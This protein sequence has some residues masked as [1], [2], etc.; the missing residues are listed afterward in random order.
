MTLR[1]TQRHT[2][3]T[4]S[5][6]LDAPRSHVSN[7]T[8]AA[9]GRSLEN[10][11]RRAHLPPRPVG[12]NLSAKNSLRLKNPAPLC[13]RPFTP[14]FSMPFDSRA[15]PRVYTRFIVYIPPPLLS[16]TIGLHAP[17]SVPSLEPPV[18]SRCLTHGAARLRATHTRSR[19]ASPSPSPIPPTPTPRR[20]PIQLGTHSD[21]IGVVRGVDA[22]RLRP[23]SRPIPLRFE[24]ETISKTQTQQPQPQRLL[25]AGWP[26]SHRLPT[27]ISIS[28]RK[29]SSSPSSLPLHSV[30]CPTASAGFTMIVSNSTYPDAS[31]HLD[32][33]P[34]P[35]L[36]PS[37]SFVDGAPQRRVA[38]Y[39]HPRL[40]LRPSRL[41]AAGLGPSSSSHGR[42]SSNST[43]LPWT[44]PQYAASSPH[45]HQQSH[46]IP[47]SRRISNPCPS[48]SSSGAR[49]P[50][51]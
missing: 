39:P 44:E 29:L 23:E 47:T 30:A 50:I 46:P 37:A 41:V 48:A 26:A 5:A 19:D 14:E 36:Y 4:S 22:L 21:T 18:A 33:Y 38:S 34:V 43:S 20:Y 7:T 13:L 28:I 10:R 45:N 35:I 31:Q 32:P 9:A 1:A 51:Q 25:A 2:P 49:L 27:L 42:S 3:L 8:R 40:A 12:D 17:C 15:T 16:S 24:V 11:L 6:A